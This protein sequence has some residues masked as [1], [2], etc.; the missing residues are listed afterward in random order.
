MKQS[1]TA[2]IFEGTI[3]GVLHVFHAEQNISK[4]IIHL[5]IHQPSDAV[6]NSIEEPRYRIMVKNKMPET[7]D[8]QRSIGFDL[9]P[10]ALRR[11][12][13]QTLEEFKN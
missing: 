11:I 12:V 1:E 9:T 3:D 13:R 7:Y 8:L 5:T 10:A 2:R 6:F 4:D